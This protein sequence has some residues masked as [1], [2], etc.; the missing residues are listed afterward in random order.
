MQPDR[1]SA[2]SLFTY[3]REYWSDGREITADMRRLELGPGESKTIEMTWIAEGSSFTGA[4]I[5]GILKD[6]HRDY[7][8]GISLCIDSCG[9]DF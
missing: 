6:E 7:K 5:F 8:V 9:G 1:V 3:I 2:K 4:D